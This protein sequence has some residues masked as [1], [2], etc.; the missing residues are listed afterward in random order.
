MVHFNGDALF[1][2]VVQHNG[3]VICLTCTMWGED[4]IQ[5]NIYRQSDGLATQTVSDIDLS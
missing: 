2:Y 4:A 3:V 5:V 1:Q